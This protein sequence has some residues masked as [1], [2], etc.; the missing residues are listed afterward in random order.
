MSEQMEGYVELSIETGQKLN[1][2][3][4]I[5]RGISNI[6]NQ[7][8]FSQNKIDINKQWDSKKIELVIVVD[9]NRL[10]ISEFSPTSDKNVKERVE[11]TVKFTKKMGVSP[12]FQGVEE[13]I[14]KYP[15]QDWLAD[16][17]IQDYREKAPDDVNA[18]IDTAISAGGVRIAGSY[19]FGDKTIY[20]KSSAG[21]S[22]S[23]AGTYYNFTVRAF[24]DELDASGQGLA[25]GR[26]P[27]NA[28]QEILAAGERAGHFSKLH[29]GAKQAKRGKYDIIMNPAVAADLLGRIPAMANPLMILMGRSALGDKMGEKLGPDYVSVEDNGLQKDGLRSSP[30]DIEGTPRQNTPIFKDGV[31]I[32]FLHNTT[33][34]KM[35]GGTSTGNGELIRFGMGTKFLGPTP[36]SLVFNNGDHSFEEL[37]EGSGPAVFVTCN[38]YTRF[39]SVISTE[40]STIPRDAAFIVENG[41]LSQPIKNFRISDNLL[42]QFTNIGAMGND[43]VQVKWWEIMH[44]TWIGSVRVKDCRITTATQ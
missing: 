23:Y 24:Q 27:F 7:I 28:E 18:S 20:L 2:D 12:F 43:R 33:T 34:A 9:E 8:R 32:N 1:V 26:I 40:Y 11:A 42:R 10:S 16:T 6:E 21:P 22:G 36:T 39:T 3:L 13:K 15:K 44:P 31:L 14:S 17:K 19:L 4:I 25:C 41:E 5:A 29:K 30:F 37:L 35:A 38:W